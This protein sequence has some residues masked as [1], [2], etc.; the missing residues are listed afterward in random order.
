ME[1]RGPTEQRGQTEQLESSEQV[2]PKG[3][4]GP[5][6]HLEPNEQLGPKE[7]FEPSAQF[8]PSDQRGVSNCCTRW[9]CKPCTAGSSAPSAW[10]SR[11]CM[12]LVMSPT[13]SFASSA[14]VTT[15]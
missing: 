11:D 7:Q 9:R 13:R 15:V 5:K 14:L 6:E 8:E 3:P 10:K 1:Q 4:L 2:G 12:V